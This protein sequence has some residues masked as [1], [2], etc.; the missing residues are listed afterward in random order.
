MKF[1]NG[2]NSEF[3]TGIKKEVHEYFESKGI[4]Q[5]ADRSICIKGAS[6]LTCYIG[7]YFMIYYFQNNLLM[8]LS[9]AILMGLSGVMVVFNIVHDASHSAISSN[10]SAN[11]F[12]CYLGDLIGIN[13]YI[14][15]IRHNIQHH[16][17]TNVLGGDIIIE[18]VPLVRLN[19]DQPLKKFHRFQQFYTPI[20]YAFYTL[21]WIFIIDVKLFLKKDICN[22]HNLKHSKKQW[23]ILLFFKTFYVFYILVCP[24]LF[25]SIPWYLVITGFMIMHCFGGLLLSLVAVLGHFV[26][27]TSFPKPN[28]N[29]E[30]ETTWSEHELEATI[31]FAPTSRIIHWITGGLNTHVAHHL[32]PKMCHCHYYEITPII[33]EYCLANGYSYR[34]ESLKGAI[35]SHFKYLKKLSKAA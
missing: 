8:A 12:L 3:Y 19:P 24:I 1:K 9:F 17:F 7:S 21:F 18:N 31:D 11:K 5:Y 25:T 2:T 14:W 27:N 23:I 26:L 34:Q 13:T 15:D 6:L 35:V 22:L 32:F 16:T 10:R 20:F 28:D 30:I 4:D 29:D 33:K